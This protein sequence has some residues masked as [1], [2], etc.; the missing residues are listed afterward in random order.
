MSTP[1]L[2]EAFH[3]LP[4]RLDEDAAEDVS[5]VF[6]FHLNGEQSGQFFVTI[7]SGLCMVKEGSHPNPQVSITMSGEDCLAMLHGKVDGHDVYMSGR[8]QVSGDLGLAIQLK[9]L[10]P[11]M[12]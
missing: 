2:S 11:S 9:G 3:T 1:S 7:D 5:A 10:F 8:V 12:G 6:Q 4:S